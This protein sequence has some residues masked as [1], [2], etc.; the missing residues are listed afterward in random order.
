MPTTSPFPKSARRPHIHTIAEQINEKFDQIA[1]QWSEVFTAPA[2]VSVTDKHDIVFRK[3]NNQW[4]F[5]IDQPA[6]P[7]TRPI[8][9]SSAPLHV[10]LEAAA[11]LS[12][13]LVVACK[14]KNDQVSRA[15]EA[16]TT[17]GNI[18]ARESHK[19]LK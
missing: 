2:A 3:R 5:F 16:L 9:I 14:N 7:D 12:E 17:L 18:V 6:N 10:R 1:E 4:D 8:H 13:L 19:C 11:K 15:Q